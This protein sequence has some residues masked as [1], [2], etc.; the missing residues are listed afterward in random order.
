[1][2]AAWFPGAPLPLN[3]SV[4]L[5]V[6][7]QPCDP[8]FDS[9]INRSGFIIKRIYSMTELAGCHLTNFRRGAG[10]AALTLVI[11]RG[12]QRS[13]LRGGQEAGQGDVEAAPQIPATPRL[14]EPREPGRTAGAQQ[15][16][17]GIH[18]AQ[19]G[20][21]PAAPAAEQATRADVPGPTAGRAR[22]EGETPGARRQQA[23][24]AAMPWAAAPA[25][26]EAEGVAPAMLAGLAQLEVPVPA[27]PLA[28]GGAAA[29][30][31]A[32]AALQEAALLAYEEVLRAA[33]ALGLPPER[34]DTVCGGVQAATEEA[35][36]C[37]RFLGMEYPRLRRACAAG[38]MDVVRAWMERVAGS[39]GG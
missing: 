5:E 9:T 2:L 3:I 36:G 21:L 38:A 27:A 7:G 37:R 13:A 19:G 28:A 25:A 1:M 35:G 16:G 8:P 12:G 20:V 15:Q 22:R 24:P 31:A 39:G 32:A 17:A 29:L 34:L 6:D 14:A 30:N 23:A 11:T 18:R 33:E 10:D 4:Q 26:V